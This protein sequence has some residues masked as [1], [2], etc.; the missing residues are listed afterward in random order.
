M[1]GRRAHG[2]RIQMRSLFSKGYAAYRR[3]NWDQ[4]Q[5][6]F[7]NCLQISTEGWAVSRLFVD[8]IAHLRSHA[9]FVR[10]GTVFGTCPR[11]RSWLYGSVWHGTDVH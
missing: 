4:A 6:H 1:S 11:N 3:Q 8:R 5:A 9:T 7:E 10:I 2:K